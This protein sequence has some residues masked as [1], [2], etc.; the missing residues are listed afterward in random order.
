MLAPVSIE[1]D[2][3]PI[4]TRAEKMEKEMNAN[5]W[6]ELRQRCRELAREER[7]W[8]RRLAEHRAY[9][10]ASDA[11]WIAL[12]NRRFAR[13]ERARIERRLARTEEVAR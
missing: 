2:T 3:P 11:T 10:C 5:E 13:R 8:E 9:D 12:T 1:T 4:G 6:L 7:W